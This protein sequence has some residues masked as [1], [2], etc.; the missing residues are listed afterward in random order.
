MWTPIKII[1]KGQWGLVTQSDNTRVA[2]PII[3]Y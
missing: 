1:P 2:K 3:Y